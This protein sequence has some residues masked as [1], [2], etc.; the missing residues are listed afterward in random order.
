MLAILAIFI[1]TVHILGRES[2]MIDAPTYSGEVLRRIHPKSLLKAIQI[3][4]PSIQTNELYDVNG[5]NPNAL[6]SG[7]SFY[8][9]QS[10]RFET[11]VN[12]PLLIVNGYE[13]P[14]N[15][16]NDID[17]LSVSKVTVCKDAATTAF[18]GIKAVQGVII[19]ETEVVD[20]NNKIELGYDFDSDIQFA[21]LDG[22]DLMNSIQK[23]E[24]E[25]KR[26]LYDKQPE[27]YKERKAGEN[28]DWL[29]MPLR[30]SF[31]QK[32]RLSLQGRNENLEYRAV[33]LGDIENGVMKESSR[34][35]IGASTF[36][37]YKNE[38]LSVSNN[39]SVDVIDAESPTYGH[40]YEW[41]KI[42]PYFTPYDKAGLPIRYLGEKS[43]DEIIWD[44]PLY[45]K[46]LNSENI[47]DLTRIINNLN[48]KWEIFSGFSLHGA[49]TLANEQSKNNIFLSPDSNIYDVSDENKGRYTI[50][51]G[52]EMS[53]QEQFW[54]SYFYHS[55][56]H[57]LHANLGGDIFSSNIIEDGFTGVGISSDDMNYI[58][59]SQH[60]GSGAP[61]GE[62]KRER[63][64]SGHTHLVWNFNDAL[65]LNLVGRLDKSSMLSPNNRTANSFS[66][67]L[68][69]NLAQGLNMPKNWKNLSIKASYGHTAGYSFSQYSLANPVY[70]YYDNNPFLD[71]NGSV[72]VGSQGLLNFNKVNVYNPNLKWKTQKTFS[73][74]ARLDWNILFADLRFYNSDMDNLLSFEK[75]NPIYGTDYNFGNSCGLRNTG[76]EYNVGLN[77]IKNN[78]DFSLSVVTSGIYNRNEITSASNYMS[79]L[80][81]LFYFGTYGDVVVGNA[82]DG[83][84]VAESA[85]VEAETGKELFY[86]KD[87]SVSTSI[88]VGDVAY[89]GSKSPKFRG[90]LG[91]YGSWK[92]FD[93]S[94]TFSYSLG[95]LYYDV[96]SALFVDG[97]N[98]YQNLPN[99]A[100]S[101]WYPNMPNPESA[102]YPLSSKS[103]IGSSRFIYNKNNF[104]LSSLSISYN[105]PSKFLERI[106]SKGINL[107]L[108]TYDL[109]NISNVD[110][111]EK[112]Y[113]PGAASLLFSLKLKF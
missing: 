20:T 97:A 110:V 96:Y 57:K 94:A 72:G 39:L 70:G 48:L 29:R 40:L 112:I 104:S 45:E 25:N 36:I 30:N 62:R 34:N 113:Y 81:D 46:S 68:S 16:I 32:H 18:Y 60:Y 8:G 103:L 23:L 73:L 59:F 2:R 76:F 31:S 64:L 55:G 13:L 10:T 107:G 101:K 79:I 100:K 42:N 4:E 106:Y 102:K 3:I 5:A 41:A 35:N 98:D 26:G 14:F 38:S 50:N 58:S 66:S 109:F 78:E 92:G 84:Y 37:A 53:F 91:L 6:L 65:E 15:R 47:Q 85:G 11:D 93:Y 9:I 54:A 27:L 21:K 22:F 63:L 49:F 51:R 44:S 105:L 87:G 52:K 99:F 86:M 12:F 19:V 75:E 83:I 24:F 82:A 56:K 61:L 67:A 95:E 80:K 28:V 7:I 108:T 71:G 33:L 74:S 90:R 89:L 1:F 111:P 17:I 77:I 43:N 69:Y 88:S